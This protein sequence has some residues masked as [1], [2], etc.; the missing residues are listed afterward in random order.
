MAVPDQSTVRLC[1]E[2]VESIN[3]RIALVARA[4]RE[5]HIADLK[6]LGVSATVQPEFEGGLEMVRQALLLYGR[7][8]DS[9]LILMS[10]IRR[11]LYE[12][13]KPPISCA[14]A[15]FDV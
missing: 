2:R 10:L 9:I 13:G 7:R 12:E 5:Y 3:P 4:V 15:V 8:E 1:V 6:R 11:G 14:K